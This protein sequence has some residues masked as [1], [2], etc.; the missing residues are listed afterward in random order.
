MDNFRFR[1]NFDLNKNGYLSIS[2]A[3]KNILKFVKRLVANFG[4]IWMA[5]QSL[6]TFV[7]CADKPTA[8]EPKLAGKL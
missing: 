2:T 6:Y 5:L 3:K 4:K 7:L 8:I 1:L